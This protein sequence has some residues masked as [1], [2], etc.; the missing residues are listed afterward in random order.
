MGASPVFLTG[1][2]L[3]GVQLFGLQ[4]FGLHALG[5]NN[6]DRLSGAS[7]DTP[8]RPPCQTARGHGFAAV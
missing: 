6:V 7:D 3:F 1:H 5:D 2:T 4:V 8:T